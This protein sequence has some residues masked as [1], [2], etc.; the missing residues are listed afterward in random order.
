MVCENIFTAPPRPNGHEIDYVT[1]FFGDSNSWRA[2]KLH[3]WFQSYNVFAEWEDFVYWWS[4][5]REGSVSAAC[6]AGLFDSQD[7]TSDLLFV[8]SFV[9]ID[10]C[11]YDQNRSK[12]LQNLFHALL[13]NP[14]NKKSDLPPKKPKAVKD[15]GG[16]QG[17]VWPWSKIQWFV[18]GFKALEKKLF[19]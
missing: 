10:S 14:I 2:S 6:A 7:L 19:W 18:R 3:Y 16:G 12:S 17:L 11:F 9:T 5:S 1:I 8:K 15:R 4:F 13:D